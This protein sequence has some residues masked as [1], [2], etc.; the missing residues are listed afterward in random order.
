MPENLSWDDLRLVLAVARQGTLSGAARLLGL[1]HSTIYRRLGAL[2]QQ[3]GV[4][5]FE[6]YRDGYTPTAAGETASAMAAKFA[7]DVTGL[8]RRLSG[9]D[10]RPSGT[11][12][13]ATTH[14][15]ALGIAMP[16]LAALRAAHPQ[17]EIELVLSNE[18]ANL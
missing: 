6:R 12:R 14:T 15:L 4:R 13:I 2:E 8:E 10:L 5:L 9:Q 11:V 3:I 17:I 7:D 1:T 18:M 16:H